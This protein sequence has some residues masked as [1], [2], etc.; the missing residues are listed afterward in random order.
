M[1]SPT[2]VIDR[3][4]NGRKYGGQSVIR[5]FES[6]V[7][8]LVTALAAVLRLFY[9]TSKSF[10]LDEGL[11]LYLGRADFAS[12]R[13]F[14]GSVE[15]NM[16]LYYAL[17]RLWF[18][19]GTGEYVVRLLS[20]IPAIA[21]IPVV[22]AI[23]ARLAGRR[24]GQVAA[25]LLA[26]QPMHVEFSQ[27]A[28]SYAWAVLLVCLSSLY[29]LRALD[30]PSRVNFTIYAFT[31][32]L[33]VYAH[34][35]AGLVLVAH[36]AALFFRDREKVPLRKLAASVLLL[37]VL[38]APGVVAILNSGNHLGW[39]L[40]PTR[41]DI[42]D[43]LYSLSLSKLRCLVYVFLW[44]A[45]VWAAIKSRAERW[46]SGFAGLWL[47]LPVAITIA[48]SYYKPL[49]VS[50]YLLVCV[51]ASVILAAAGLVRL[52]RIV[53]VILLSLAVLY[54]ISGDRFYYRHPQLTEDWRGATKHVLSNISPGE[55]IVLL[56]AFSM[57]TFDYY[58]QA[59]G[60][61]D[62]TVL[63][64]ETAAE[65][66]T[67]NRGT[68][69]FLASGIITPQIGPAEVAAFLTRQKG[70]YSVAELRDFSGVKLWRV[71]HCPAP[72]GK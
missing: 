7:L 30:R 48:A 18:H 28:R 16:V 57:L 40:K 22:Y 53:A 56:P 6:L 37:A 17:L 3:N 27:E 45:A 8:V 1:D 29:Y 41:H 50:R 14:V 65:I 60:V 36:W 67:T 26:V 4:T 15:M 13:H 25:L 46:T 23:A 68:V 69:W 43:L 49:L 10:N 9:L 62:G 72:S 32:A 12:F 54:S 66:P 31:S 52:N 39:V 42:L 21:T 63:E 19:V 47:F 51:P 24:A 5:A 35:F 44:G 59:A 20:V 70:S 58:R 33:A 38:I 61:P 64:L 71:E 11:S 2:E 55:I 34:V